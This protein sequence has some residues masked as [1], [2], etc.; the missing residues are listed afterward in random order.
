MG[1]VFRSRK[2]FVTIWVREAE[3]DDFLRKNPFEEY[4]G[5]EGDISVSLP[6]AEEE[7]GDIF[8][9]PKAF[10]ERQL[11]LNIAEQYPSKDTAMVVCGLS[12]KR[13][14][15]YFHTREDMPDDI[16]CWF[17]SP[18]ALMTVTVSESAI[19]KITRRELVVAGDGTVAAVPETILFEGTVLLAFSAMYRYRDAISAAHEKILHADKP[20]R[21]PFFIAERP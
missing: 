11:F 16:Q 13:L 2:P 21:V 19:V 9:I 10:R 5:R 3:R 15:P 8:R 6:R 18:R 17:S 12:G 4:W 1:K 7:D 20:H 14:R